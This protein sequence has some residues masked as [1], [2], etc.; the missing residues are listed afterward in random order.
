LESKQLNQNDLQ[1]G[2][3]DD[4]T[5][6]ATMLVQ[7]VTLRL[8]VSRSESI[9]MDGMRVAEAMAS[10]LGQTLRFEELHP[11]EEDDVGILEDEVT[12]DKKEKKERRRNRTNRVR[13]APRVLVDPD[14]EYFTDD[15]DSSDSSQSDS[16]IDSHESDES[17]DSNSSWGEDSLQPYPMNDDEEDLRRVPRPRT[18][19]DCLAYLLT[20]DKD[21]FAYDKQHS[22][23]MELASIVASQPLDLLDVVSTLVRVLLF[24]ED[25]FNMEE[26]AVKRW[27]SLVAFGVNIPLETCMLLVEEMRGNISL[28]T[29]LEALTILGA[30]AQ[31]LSG[32]RRDPQQK[33]IPSCCDQEVANC[34]TKLQRV[35]NLHDTSTGEDA[36]AA[37]S[38]QSSKT[39]RW[40]RP[41]T[42]PTTTTNRFGAVSVQMIYSL[43]AF[44]SQTR[45]DE[46]IW[47][48]PIGEKFLSEFLKTLSIML[49]CA[50][51]Y[52]SPALRVLSADLF[53]LAWSF[54]DAKCSEVRCAALTAMATCV[55]MVP[56]E[57]VISRAS[58]GL[59]SFLNHCSAFDENADCRRLAS[60]VGGSISEVLNQN[61]IERA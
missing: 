22:A 6:L 61:M 20:S 12:E 7:G 53:D 45:N 46:S 25:K 24:L 19:R 49:Y 8:D 31:E 40:R 58:H 30:V 34:S 11:P 52:P 2:L 14:A 54:H 42:S 44:L 35:L 59:G 55:S 28:G 47:G 51:T 37:L 17:S 27:D 56:V 15:S 10:L 18:L 50:R 38:T 23:L 41:R 33:A 43:F 9:R 48:G 3:S 60:L 21:N 4:G 29:R 39:R 16:S 26:F 13:A 1:K 57:F 36:N 32:L 5:P